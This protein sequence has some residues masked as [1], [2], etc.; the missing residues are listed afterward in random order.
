MVENVVRDGE[1]DPTVYIYLQ[2]GVVALNNKV[3]DNRRD[4]VVMLKG[5]CVTQ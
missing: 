1:V 3:I 5:Y 4:V 2:N